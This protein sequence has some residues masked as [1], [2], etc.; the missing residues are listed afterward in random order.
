[1]ELQADC[2]AGVWGHATQQRDILEQ[3]DVEEGL[4]AAAA[5]GDDRIQQRAGQGVHPEGF[6]HGSA[7]QR[8]ELVQARLPERPPRGLRYVR[9]LAPGRRN[10]PAG[11]DFLWSL[12]A[13]WMT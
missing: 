4:D 1:M 10:H 6:T 8:V 11:D 2:Y 13:T 7:A 12:P 9:K 3:G 5:V